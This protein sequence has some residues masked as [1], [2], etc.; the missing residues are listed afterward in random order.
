[1]SLIW[2]GEYDSLQ[3]EG[4]EPMMTSTPQVEGSDGPQGGLFVQSEA[5]TCTC[6][7]KVYMLLY[8]AY[9]SFMHTDI[10]GVYTCTYTMCPPILRCTMLC[11][12]G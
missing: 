2:Y 1:M 11:R 6:A 5:G 8:A 4:G 12:G 3:C 9:P 10:L 7:R